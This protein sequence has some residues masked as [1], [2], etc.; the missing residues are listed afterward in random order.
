MTPASSFSAGLRCPDDGHLLQPNESTSVP[1]AS[2]RHCDGLWFTQEAI[3][4]GGKPKLPPVSKSLLTN[5]STKANRACPQCSVK[6]NAE[7]VDDVVIDVCPACGGV[8]LDPDEYQAARRR[9]VRRRL[10]RDVPSLRQKSSRVG[11][12]IDRI[13]DVIGETLS[14]EEPEEFDPRD[15]IPRKRRD[16]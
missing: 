2:C 9:S 10:E 13:I 1:F 3:D 12:L 11:V 7:T 14:E 8:W 15:L 16:Q 4:K 5:V 6:L